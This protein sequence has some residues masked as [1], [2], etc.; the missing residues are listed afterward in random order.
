MEIAMSQSPA[1][2]R[3]TEASRAFLESLTPEQ[4]AN[5]SFPF[6]GDERYIWNYT[7]VDRNGLI[8][9]EMSETQRGLAL[10]LMETALSKRGVIQANEIIDLEL[11]L[12]EWESMQGDPSTWTRDPRR[13]WFSVFGMPGG[14]APWGWR[15]GGH[16]IGIHATVVRGEYVS[17]LP[18]FFGANPAEV[19][20]GPETGKR[21]L[22]IEE[23]LPREFVR[24]MDA[25]QAKI[26]VVDEIAPADILTKSYRVAEPGA[27]PTGLA[28]AAMNGEQREQL[29]KLIR[30]YVDRMSDDLSAA[31]WKR[32]EAAG[33]DTISFAWAGP[34]ER[35]QG[36]YYSIV[37]P[38]FLIEYDN[39][40]NG[41]NHIHSVLRDYKHDW[42]ED[43]LAAHYAVAHS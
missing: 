22:E 10:A 40:Q 2:K 23:E 18:F 28:Y 31:Y 1:I 41:A 13:Y 29:V 27:A 43:L 42:G 34:L 3:M 19:K 25:E 38:E 24:S 15:A 33:L 16:H 11:I 5:T 21:I 26:A 14:D 35:W 36:H 37:A 8:L 17:A 12:G 7:P 39:T 30:H 6:E 32:V 9:T 4:A 20:H